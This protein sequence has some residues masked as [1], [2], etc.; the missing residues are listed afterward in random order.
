MQNFIDG[1]PG[2]LANLFK[3]LVAATAVFDPKSFENATRDEPDKQTGN[4]A[5]DE[6]QSGVIDCC[7]RR[8]VIASIKDREL[9]HR[10]ARA[11]DAKNMFPSTRLALE[12]PH[13]TRLDHVE[14]GPGLAWR[15]QFG[16]R[17]IGAKESARSRALGQER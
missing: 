1:N 12:N 5:C 6:Q 17:G 13:M 14:A 7:Y 2:F 3:K 16:P 11:F 15:I 8:R 4:P 9:C 10:T